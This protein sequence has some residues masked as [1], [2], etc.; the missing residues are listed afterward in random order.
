MREIKCLLA[1]S[2]NYD[3]KGGSSSC[4]RAKGRAVSVIF[5]D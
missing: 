3:S 4:G 1:S 2:I 5:E